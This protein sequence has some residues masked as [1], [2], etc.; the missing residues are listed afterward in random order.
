MPLRLLLALAVAL[1][2]AITTSAQGRSTLVVLATAGDYPGETYTE[3]PLAPAEFAFFE[4]EPIVVD[5]S[6]ANW[7]PRVS[8]IDLSRTPG[9]IV[10]ALA[11][12]EGQVVGQARLTAGFWRDGIG[13][14]EVLSPSLALAIEPG[15][16]VRWRLQF[17]ADALSAGQYRMQTELAVTDEFGNA[18]RRE[19]PAFVIEVRRR[20]SAQP[21]ELARRVA[22]W[23][24][25]Q[26]APARAHAAVDE[27][28]RVYPDSVAVHLIRSRL[29]EAEGDT[30]RARREL[31]AAA[32]F[33]RVDR[34]TLFRRFA[35]PGQIEDLI[36][37]L[38][39]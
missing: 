8:T 5:V 24:T 16:A 13:G 12:G 18:V 39:P 31:D 14:S 28:A 33:M 27:L 2:V 26:G 29:A 25:A 38:V 7:G 4:G 32:A 37:S 36:E 17:E 22:E 1:V 23:W 11:V 19:R 6:I 20:S 9:P 34:D 30:V 10:D 35:R 3:G 15:D 21:A